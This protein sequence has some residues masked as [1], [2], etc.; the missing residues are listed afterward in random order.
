MSY[1]PSNIMVMDL[2]I[3]IAG[4]QDSEDIAYLSLCDRFLYD[5][6]SWFRFNMYHKTIERRWEKLYL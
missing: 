2:V 6:Y 1:L 5:Y 3:R 4:L